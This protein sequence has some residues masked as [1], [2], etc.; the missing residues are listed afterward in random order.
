MEKELLIEVKNMT[1]FFGPTQ[2]LKGVDM[3]F[4][5]GEIRGL[6]GENGSG[7]STVTS[8]IAGMQ[9]ASGGT[10]TYKGQSWKPENMVEA[11]KA[12]ISMVLQE[13]NTI[14]DCTVAENLLAGRFDEFSKFGFV[15]M[16]KA[17][18]EAEK[19]LLSFGITNIHAK[20][21]INKL[22]FE[23]RKLIEIVRCVSDET[24][25]FVVDETTTALSLEGRQ[26]LYK[27]IHEL[28]EKGKCVIFISHDMDEILEQCTDLT[29][30]R[31]GNIIGHLNREEM[32]APD[33]VQRIRY[34]MVGREIGEAYYRE[35]YDTSHSDEIALE[36]KNVSFG[37][38]K[39]FSLTLHKGEILGF[40]GLSGCG[41]HEVGRAAFGLEKLESGSV[42]RNGKEIKT[43]LQAIE[44]G[45]GYISKNRDKEA[46]ILDGSIQDNIVLPLLPSLEHGT[47][48]NPASEKDRADK[49]IDSFRIKCGTGKQWVNTL[50]G[51]NKQKVSFAKWTARGS[52]YGLSYPRR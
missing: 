8:I 36:L 13:A 5:R 24:E 22:T 14:P 16:K 23:D 30:L 52:D 40:G 7:K 21:S 48:I 32:D 51:G 31:D 37:P 2:A 1:K 25:V 38:I 49:E 50:S 47:F 15:S 20:D 39:D 42:V 18:A 3:R 27:L 10:M 41:M 11:Q 12:G 19:M 9:A 46:L 35:D 45:I 6:I 26:I 17:N 43:C 33:A 28:K 34:M 29:V 44:S 4:Y